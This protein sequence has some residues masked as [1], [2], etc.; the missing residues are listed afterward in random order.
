MTINK[1]INLTTFNPKN[2]AKFLLLILINPYN[3]LK[4]QY[5]N[6]LKS[7]KIIL[8]LK[9]YKKCMINNKKII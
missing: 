1:I 6:T 8:I 7:L 2:F 9:N 5:E 3:L 4:N